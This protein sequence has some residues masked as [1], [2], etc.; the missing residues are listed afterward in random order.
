MSAAIQSLWIGGPLSK[1]E[2]LS[3]RSFLANGHDYHLYVYDDVDSV[4]SGAV[5]MHADEIVPRDRVFRYPKHDSVAGFANAF[6][7]KLLAERGGWWVDTDLI[8][9]KPFALAHDMVLAS[10]RIEAQTFLCNAVIK[11]PAGSPVMNWN[12][13]VCEMK[14][15]SKLRWGETGSQLMTA[16]VKRF[17]LQ[18][19]IQSEEV[20]C[21][22]GY[23]DW[24]RLIDPDLELGFSRS[25]L[26]VHFWNEM[27]RRDEQDKNADYSPACLYE[28]LKR[29]YPEK[30]QPAG[31]LESSIR[32]T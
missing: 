19:F 26:A 12:W 1:L 32:G 17:E 4:P 8:C 16:A 23:R 24:K 11:A 22:V 2:Q 27:W 30:E 28:R 20:F 5:L 10:E 9:L 13:K 18:K 21:P 25:T 15:P 7:Y 14:D 3:I 31:R 29:H 6:R